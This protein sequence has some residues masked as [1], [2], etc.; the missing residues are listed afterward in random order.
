MKSLIRKI[1][2]DREAS[3][4]AIPGVRSSV[5]CLFWEQKA[6][7]SIPSPRI[8][9]LVA[10]SVERSPDKREAGGSYPSGGKFFR[11]RQRSQNYDGHYVPLR[12]GETGITA[13]F[14]VAIPGSY[15]GISELWLSY[16]GITPGCGPGDEVS[17]TSSHPNIVL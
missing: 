11:H 6:E 1:F 13:A 16:K 14:E 10:Q 15:P 12:C 9:A 7:G 4:T 3:N 2:V 17:I 8:V 5:D